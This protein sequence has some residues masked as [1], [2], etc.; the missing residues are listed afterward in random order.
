MYIQVLC[1]LEVNWGEWKPSKCLYRLLRGSKNVRLR[2]LIARGK[3]SSPYSIPDM[4]YLIRSL[5]YAVV[6]SKHRGFYEG[7]EEPTYRIVVSNGITY[8]FKFNRLKSE[9][10]MKGIE[11]FLS[12]LR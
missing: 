12:S 5:N 1:S 2:K 7:M 3:F 8:E 6:A 11:T 9:D 4:L 10:M